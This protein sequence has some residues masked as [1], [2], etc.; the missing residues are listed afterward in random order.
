MI[1]AYACERYVI[2][3]DKLIIRASAKVNKA[4]R[5]TVT[6]QKSAVDS[7]LR[8]ARSALRSLRSRKKQNKQKSIVLLEQSP[9]FHFSSMD[10][11][12]YI[13]S[14][15]SVIYEAHDLIL[16][17]F[18]V[19]IWPTLVLKLDLFSS[20]VSSRSHCKLYHLVRCL[21]IIN[22]NYKMYIVNFFNNYLLAV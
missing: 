8:A 2:V 14:F 5:C 20:L 21:E 3:G 16:I 4:A 13:I 17:I 10:S 18:Q 22:F 7:S 11:L 19:S 15:S 12:K 6:G 9:W 1:F